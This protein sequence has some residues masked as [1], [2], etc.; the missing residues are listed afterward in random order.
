MTESSP[1]LD[2][3]PTRGTDLGEGL[4]VHRALPTR[5]RR[6][7][8]AWCFL[9]HIGPIDFRGGSGMHVGA[10]PHTGLQTFTWMIAGQI[11]HRDSLGTDLLI[12]PGEVNLMTAGHGI[13]HTEDSPANP[14]LVHAA[15]LWIALPPSQT[16]C[17]P[18]FANYA[19][20]PR[21]EEQGSTLTLLAGAYGG[22]SAPTEVH[23]PLLGLEIVSQAATRIQL[24]LRPDF[25]Y[26]LLPLEGGLHLADQQLLP[27]NF[28]YL[29]P[30]SQ[31]L[32]LELE[33]NSR[34][35]LLGGE[36][37]G[38]ELHMW[39]NFVALDRPTITQAQR[40]WQAEHPRFGQV[41]G[42]AQRRLPAPVPPWALP[43]T[44]PNPV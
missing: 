37:F 28:G 23:T 6:M 16:D 38:R 19:N 35:L 22:H 27:Q 9:D 1:R 12:Q 21:W 24:T 8:G 5:Q 18:A 44:P 26:G 40:D 17:A 30:G 10:H 7:V 29:A 20:L 41:P 25:E 31:T 43:L 13:S 36:P 34:I 4:Q 14:G 32:E 39:W 2:I 33:A 3:I 11:H 15:Q 42:G